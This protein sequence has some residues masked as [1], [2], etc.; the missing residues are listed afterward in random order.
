MTFPN[1]FCGKTLQ[2]SGEVGRDNRR[3][4]DEISLVKKI[5]INP[6]FSWGGGDKK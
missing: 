5:P 4:E 3:K 6:F 2:R 1:I